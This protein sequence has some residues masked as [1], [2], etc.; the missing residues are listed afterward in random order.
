M[1][2]EEYKEWI[3]KDCKK[4]AEL[5]VDN[6]H[7]H[8]LFNPKLSRKDLRIVEKLIVLNTKGTIIWYMEAQELLD[9]IEWKQLN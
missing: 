5:L 9:K 8:E 3:E 6:L 1:I 4:E 2:K 7:D